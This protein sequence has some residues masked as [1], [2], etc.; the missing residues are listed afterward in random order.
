MTCASVHAF[1]I[2]LGQYHRKPLERVYCIGLVAHPQPKPRVKAAL[3]TE[4]SQLFQLQPSGPDTVPFVGLCL[5]LQARNQ[6]IGVLEAYGLEHCT[7]NETVQSL[8]SMA[9]QHLV[10]VGPIA[11]CD[12]IGRIIHHLELITAPDRSRAGLMSSLPCLCQKEE[13][14]QQIEIVPRSASNIR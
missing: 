8:E 5:P 14:R 4:E 13:L 12:E 7:E 2:C 11:Y 1:I 9:T 3:E 6:L 10:V